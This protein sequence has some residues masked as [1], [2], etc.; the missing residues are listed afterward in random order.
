MHLSVWGVSA[1]ETVLGEN[2]AFWG[3]TLE[4]NMAT[5][6]AATDE[7]WQ[8]LHAALPSVLPKLGVLWLPPPRRRVFTEARR[9]PFVPSRLAWSL[10]MSLTRL[11]M[12]LHGVE[13]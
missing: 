4:H 3:W 5:S 11:L 10:T 12:L 7:G 2:N 6:L 8:C 13:V 1:W 9:R